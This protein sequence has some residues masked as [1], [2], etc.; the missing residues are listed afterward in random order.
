MVVVAQYGTDCR[1]FLILSPW[2]LESSQ[3]QFGL[4]G[5][6]R[7]ADGFALAK[8]GRTLAGE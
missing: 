3:S 2:V 8:S 6:R 7:T 5:G 4:I 1:D